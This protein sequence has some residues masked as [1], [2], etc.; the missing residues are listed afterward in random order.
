MCDANPPSRAISPAP[1]LPS[2]PQPALSVRR[3]LALP[4]Q[5]SHAMG[6][7]ADALVGSSALLRPSSSSPRYTPGALSPRHVSDVH[8]SVTPRS[9]LARAGGHSANTRHR[10][11]GVTSA[12]TSRSSGQHCSLAAAASKMGHQRSLPVRSGDRDSFSDDYQP[13]AV[14]RSKSEAPTRC[15]P[16][17]A[18]HP[19]EQPATSI[20]K[21]VFSLK[22]PSVIDREFQE[23]FSDINML[24]RGEQ[25]EGDDEGL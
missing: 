13:L 19:S 15:S 3:T 7:R 8:A 20:D 1:S 10:S 23:I 14:V 2:T 12:R 24:F 4:G 16:S 11:I 18:R 9:I 25:D 6:I 21:E 5:R 22:R 17:E